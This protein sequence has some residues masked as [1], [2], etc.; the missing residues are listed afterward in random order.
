T[1]PGDPGIEIRQ[2][3][4]LSAGDAANVTHLSFGAHTA[5]HI[6]APAH[7]IEGAEG[8]DHIAD[9]RVVDVAVY[10]IGDDAVPVPALAHFVRR[11]PYANEIMRLKKPGAI[12]SREP[13]TC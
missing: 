5:T 2:W 13:L 4:A 6:D 10:D 8:T 1:Y 7:F 11:Q 9:V 3:A 12:F